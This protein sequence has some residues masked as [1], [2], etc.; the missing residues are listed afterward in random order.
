[1]IY[2][3][4]TIVIKS[5]TFIVCAKCVKKVPLHRLKDSIHLSLSVPSHTIHEH[6]INENNKNISIVVVVKL[7][8]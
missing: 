1:M 3:Y 7:M 4:N 6:V 8:L 2:S 5:A